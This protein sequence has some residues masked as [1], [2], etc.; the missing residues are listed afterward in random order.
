[1]AIEL[2][3]KIKPKNNGT[4]ALVD[5]ADV[6]M[7]DGSRLSDFN[8]AYPTA[9]GAAKIKPGVYYSYGEVSTLAI[10][11]EEGADGMANEYLFEFIPTDEFSG[12]TI[13][14]EVKWISEPQYPA[15]KTCQVSILQG[16]AVMGCA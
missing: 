7:P 15:G 9:A 6:E 8:P 16:L 5:A 13:T 1:M 2:I 4:F 10:T 11:L 14:P 12:L 3:S